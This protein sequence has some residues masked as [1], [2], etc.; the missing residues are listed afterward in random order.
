[1]LAPLVAHNRSDGAAGHLKV[2]ETTAIKNGCVINCLTEWAYVAERLKN[3]LMI[4]ADVQH[5]K[6]RFGFIF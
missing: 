3:T 4:E 1:M 5:F 6:G 2:V